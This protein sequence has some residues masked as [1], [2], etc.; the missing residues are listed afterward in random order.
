M[1]SV[2]LRFLELANA[3]TADAAKSLVGDEEAKRLLE[4]IAIHE[5]NGE[6]MHVTEAMHLAHIASPATMHRKLDKLLDA[7][8]VDLV[9]EGVNRRTKY[10][11]LTN[12]AKKYFE[13]MNRVMLEVNGHTMSKTI[14]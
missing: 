12:L 13:D 1:K 4:I 9:F 6:P 11:V 8:L 10:L 5:M 14:I 7:G 3:L 2:Y